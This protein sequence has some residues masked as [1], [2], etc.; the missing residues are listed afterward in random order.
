MK[1]TQTTAEVTD[2]PSTR[3]LLVDAPQRWMRQ[4]ADLI[5]ALG[6]F[7]SIGIVVV[8]SM[9]ARL[10]VLGVTSDVRAAT[11]SF[12]EQ[13]FF[14]PINILEGLVSFF[15]PVAVV[16]TIIF[17]RRWRTVVTAVLATIVTVAL[18]TMTGMIAQQIVHARSAS[19]VSPLHMFT[20]STPYL[21][22][23]SALLTIAGTFRGSR[24][25]RWGWIL[26]V[27][28]A[29][30]L[31][32]QGRQNLPSTVATVLLG[33][34][35]ALL[36]RFIIGTFPRRVTGAR[37][38]DL[39]KRAGVD[40]QEIIRCDS[41]ICDEVVAWSVLSYAPLGY[42]DSG[43]IRRLAR[44][45]Q[46]A[47]N[48]LVPSAAFT[49]SLPST[50]G[51]A[52]G[53]NAREM[54]YHARSSYPMFRPVSVS[55]TYLVRDR[56][57]LVY[58]VHV[59]D[60]DRLIVGAMADLWRQLRLKITYREGS[61]TLHDAAQQHVL[62]QLATEKAKVSPRLFVGDAHADSTVCVVYRVSHSPLLDD[63]DGRTITDEALDSFWQHLQQAHVRGISHG[64][65]HAGCVRL[66]ADGLHITNW[67]DGSL[68][69]SETV[70]FVDLAQG[71]T[72]LAGVVGIDRAVDSFTRAMPFERVM[73]VVPLLQKTIMPA[74][75]REDFPKSKDIGRI[76]QALEDRLPDTGSMEPVELNRFSPKTIITVSL[77]VFAIY[78]LAASVNFTDL[79]LAIQAANP[80]W[81]MLSFGAGLLT[82]LGAAITLKAYTQEHIPLGQS[83]LIQVVA[84]LVTLV[85]P[86]GIG[87]AALNLRFLQKKNVDTAPALATVTVVQLAQFI[88]TVFSLIVLTLV[89]GELGALSMPSQSIVI[90]IVLALVA[91]GAIFVIR[92]L[93][94][95]IFAKIQPTVEQIWPRLVWLGTH[96]RRLAFGF[97]GSMIMTV[98][99]VACFGFALGSFGYQLPLVTLAVTYL[100]SNSVGS[101]VPSP[102]GIGPVE[103]ALTGGLVLTGIPYSVALSTAVLYRLFTFWG[104]V[105]LGWIAL[106]IATK[107]NY[108]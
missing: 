53:V 1:T 71:L 8:L 81:M 17:R 28:L 33:V 102:G 90:S 13:I 14:V 51:P 107:R 72:M 77:G 58:H 59:L 68:L 87:P 29:F 19:V 45:W 10:T 39:I 47:D 31:V 79:S 82:Y 89:T 94:S 76:R 64:D 35:I 5:G 105:P 86:A 7:A 70:R 41:E 20:D 46:N 93:R 48:A 56:Q 40:P 44:M 92:P 65:I 18:T 23:I 67:Q 4:P 6:A 16:G 103:A 50:I 9:Y 98:A 32:L 97:L 30:L 62:M 73:S 38:V 108:I 84:S 42:T 34:G 26:T 63:V 80:M 24:L 22:A 99:F 37:F 21:A 91:I 66:T 36:V 60:E 101:L 25:V 96:P 106:Q 15:V 11:S 57:D 85:A 75:T 83:V 104:R 100:V 61:R 55:R 88:T 54:A 3:V 69:T 78:F 49:Q 2:D 12:V 95:W 43:A 74:R 27:A 52:S